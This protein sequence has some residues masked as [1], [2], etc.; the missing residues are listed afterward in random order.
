[1]H[2]DRVPRVLRRDRLG[3]G[4]SGDITDHYTHTDAEMIE[5]LLARQT[6]RWRGD[7]H[8]GT[9]RA[10]S[11]R[12]TTLRRAHSRRLAGSV[13]GRRHDRPQERSL[14]TSRK[15]VSKIGRNPLTWVGAGGFEPPASRL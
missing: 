8:P 11:R 3:H 15:R 9:D 12:R 1:M 7:Q 2:R 6:E 10:E 14:P 13:P 4:R 5:D